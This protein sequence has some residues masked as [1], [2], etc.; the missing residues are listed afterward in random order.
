MTLPDTKYDNE[1]LRS[2]PILRHFPTLLHRWHGGRARFYDLTDSHRSLTIRVE[3]S[4]VVGNLHLTFSPVH[5]CGPVEWSPA[6]LEVKLNAYGHY[7]IYDE[8]ANVTI[9]S[10]GGIE[11]A[12]NVQP[13][14]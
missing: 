11:I 13:V 10:D 1:S 3:K 7:V 14:Y 6:N 12:E 4:G 8:E 5:I 9:I 2:H